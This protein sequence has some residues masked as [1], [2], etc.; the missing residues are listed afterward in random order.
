MIDQRQRRALSELR[1]LDWAPT[2]EDVW[3]ALDI[4][5]DG[6]NGE[7]GAALLRAFE[8]ADGSTGGSPVGLV[9]E[10]QHGAGKTH[11]LRWARER[12]QKRGGYF[13]LMGI[14][15][16]R[17]F[18]TSTVHTFLRGLRR[19]GSYRYSQLSI[20][21][22][23]LGDRA[24]VPIA[25]RHAVRGEG[26]LTPEVLD[27]FVAAVRAKDPDLGQECRRVI[28]AL[29]LLASSDDTISDLGEAW[30]LSLPD[31]EREE[32]RPWGLPGRVDEPAEVGAGISRLLAWTGPTMLAVDQIDPIFAHVRSETGAAADSGASPE[33]VTL[34]EDIGYGLMDLREKLRRTVI[35]VACLPSSWGLINEYAPPSVPGR[36]RHETR[37]SRLP[38]KEIAKQL[39]EVR[40]APLFGT[41]EFF[42]PPY[43]T[44]PIPD[45]AFDVAGSLTP[46]QLMERADDF[47]RRCLAR[48]E[49]LSDIDLTKP[50]QAYAEPR[51][52]VSG[53]RLARFDARFAEL[54]DAAQVDGALAAKTEDREMSRLLE[55]GLQAWKVEQGDRQ[56]RYRVLPG[57][58]GNPSVH[59]WLRETLNEETEDQTIWSFRALSHTN[60]RAVQARVA[61][62]VGF[63]GLNPS[64]DRRRAYLIRNEAWPRGPVSQRVRQQFLDLGGVITKIREEDL[65]TFCGPRRAVERGRSGTTRLPAGPSPCRTDRIVPD[66]LRP[67]TRRRRL[68]PGSSVPLGWS[69]TGF[70]RVVPIR[71]AL[72]SPA[73]DPGRSHP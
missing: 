21:L 18:W 54:R 20:L 56:A 26:L 41:A 34:A 38:S 12:V 57:G 50:P 43:P 4:H 36:F 42:S 11:L 30:L 15:E 68:A 45:H 6:L 69:G 44:W 71:G 52:P 51:Q 35:V 39:I 10:G 32:L 66:G 14:A 37:L 53:E 1:R 16:G 46:R 48:G 59:S 64:V 58:E 60:A 47:V 28:R 31:I 72:G 33:L 13:F 62:L 24:G 65:R 61:R 27:T 23:R 70:H 29:V 40:F 49:I 5:L 63:A 9:I 55:A 7:A 19:S 8:N 25:V 22:D 17:S 2:P 67:A 3:T 73:G